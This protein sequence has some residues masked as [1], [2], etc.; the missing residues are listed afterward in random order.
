MKAAVCSC[1]WIATAVLLF[2]PVRAS[3]P[4]QVDFAREI[5][6]LLS[7]KCFACHGPDE[8]HRE[9]GLRLDQQIGATAELESGSRAIVLGDSGESEMIRRVA[10]EDPFVRMPP[11]KSGEPLSADQIDLL[12]RWV[13]Q[14]APWSQHWSYV[15]PEPPPLPEVAQKKW[16]RGGID[17]FVLARLESDGLAPSPEADR[18]T[19]IRRVSLDLTGLPP[20]PEEVEQFIDDPRPDAYAR[21]VSRLLDSPAYGERWA[22]VWLDLARYADTNGYEKDARRTI[23]RYRDWV[24]DGLNRDMPFDQFTIEQLAGD[25]LPE[26]SLDQII[27]TAF[28]RNTMNNTEGGTDD[29]EFRVAAVVDRVNTTMQ[30]WM[31]TTIGCAQCHN[32]KYDPLTQRE[33]YEL[34]AFFNQTEDSD[35]DDNRP[36]FATPTPEQ[37]AQLDE[38]LQRIAQLQSE[39]PDAG[40]IPG[41]SSSESEGGDAEASEIQKQIE[42]LRE[43]QKNVE[44]PTT[45]IMREL[46]AD[47]RRETHIH[48]RGSFLNLGESVEAGVPSAF[49]PLPPDI[50]RDR[51]ALARWLISDDNPLTARVTVNRYWERFFGR[52]IVET[53]EDF[54]A[55]GEPPSHPELLDWLATQFIEE[56]WSMKELCRLIVTSSTYR[57]SSRVTPE[58]LEKDPQNRLYARGPRFR[59]EA[60]AVRDQA[61][62]V[63]GLLSSKMYGPSVMPPQ[64]PGV[65]QIVYSGESWETSKGEDKYRRGLYTFWR[66]TSPYPAMTVF[67][68]TS[69]EVCTV[70]RIRTNT[71]LQALVTLNDPAFVEAA[72][73]LARRIFAHSGEDV[74]AG[75]Q[76]AYLRVLSRPPRAEEAKRV[77]ELFASELAHY[78]A[79]LQAA[80]KMA[81]SEIGPPPEEMPVDVLAAW[82]VV[83][84]VLL[85]LDETLTKD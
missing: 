79:D 70:R 29:E 66:R 73:A 55:Q 51:L 5:R 13:E 44:L 57:Q 23:W 18:H 24:I 11:A 63:G 21:L 58:L 53:S 72:Q 27:A 45:P 85:N 49:A 30:V 17:Y 12:T 52:G 80:A 59:L 10:E 20:T 34:F 46:P 31:G 83:G 65:W 84:N 39:L 61:L 2:A 81:G 74:Q 64:P 33:Y 68:A 32:H 69:R 47:D 7:S 9:A 62:A 54:G 43:Q 75:I 6:P 41:E 42:A 48:V 60:E 28:H 14:G 76:H 38:L 40:E 22:R 36:T 3:E 16:P 25:L 37:K 56:G 82:T 4:A 1:A 78:K 8:N 77:A 35:K 67:D 71:P 19:L 15:P 50:P 26:P